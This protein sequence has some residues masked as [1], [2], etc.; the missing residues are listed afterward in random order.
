MLEALNPLIVFLFACYS[1]LALAVQSIVSSV[2]HV[3]QLTCL[4]DAAIESN[5]LYRTHVHKKS[6]SNLFKS[7]LSDVDSVN[8]YFLRNWRAI[9][10]EKWRCRLNLSH[11]PMI[12][13]GHLPRIVLWSR[14]P[15]QSSGFRD[16][17]GTPEEVGKRLGTELAEWR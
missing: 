7:S 6:P 15:K 1:M 5:K 10:E 11:S 16:G 2:E 9:Y 13:Q 14:R 4:R 3:G 8:S 17:I 12:C